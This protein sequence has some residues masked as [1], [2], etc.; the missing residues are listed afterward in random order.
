MS[1]PFSDSPAESSESERLWYRD[2]PGSQ[3]S[4]SSSAAPSRFEPPEWSSGGG[5]G[6]SDWASSPSPNN[7][8]AQSSS[9]SHVRLRA[10]RRSILENLPCNWFA[11]SIAVAVMAVLGSVGGFVW[12]SYEHHQASLSQM[13]RLERDVRNIRDDLDSQKN[14]VVSMQADLGKL[15]AFVN[16]VSDTSNIG[17]YNQMIK[18][19]KELLLDMNTTTTSVHKQLVSSENTVN[20]LV[21]ATTNDLQKMRSNVSHMVTEMTHTMNE[22]ISRINNLVLT[23]KAAIDI[24]VRNVSAQE[25]KYKLD[26]AKQFAAENDFVKYQLAGMCTVQ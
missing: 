18:I 15:H 7:V 19:K 9:A 17:I 1:N 20:S 10:P 5:R 23:A 6:G 26:T 8:E 12:W 21:A 25:A 13:T 3:P 14:K 22:T 24:E 16:N 4:S 2:I 11:V